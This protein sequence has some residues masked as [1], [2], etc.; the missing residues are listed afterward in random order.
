MRAIVFLNVIE[1]V[2]HALAQNVPLEWFTS[3]IGPGVAPRLLSEICW[4]SIG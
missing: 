1:V 4:L 3:T 2:A